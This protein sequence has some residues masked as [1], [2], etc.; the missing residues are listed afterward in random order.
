[1]ALS[2][3]L[4]FAAVLADAIATLGPTGNAAVVARP[5]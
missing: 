5:T 2:A 3:N 4:L 1:M